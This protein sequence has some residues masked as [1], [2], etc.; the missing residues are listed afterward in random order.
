MAIPDRGIPFAD[1][2]GNKVP[3]ILVTSVVVS[4]VPVVVDSQTTT[5]QIPTP[6][7]KSLLVRAALVA[8]T[9]GVD[10]NDPMTGK[11]VKRAASDDSDLVLTDTLDMIAGIVAKEYAAFDFVAGSTVAARTFANADRLEIDFLAVTQDTTPVG[12]CIV[13]EWMILE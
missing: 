5:Y 10:G 8:T 7:T 4:A 6:Y 11:L 2:L 12:V 3:G 13:A 1:A 9:I